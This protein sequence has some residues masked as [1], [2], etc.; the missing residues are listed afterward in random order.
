[1]FISFPVSG[2]S[3][4]TAYNHLPAKLRVL[5]LTSPPWGV[6][7][8]TSDVAI[9]DEEISVITDLFE[10]DIV[11]YCVHEFVPVHMNLSN[12]VPVHVEPGSPDERI[13]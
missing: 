13:D 4:R 1:M 7:N 10:C 9:K 8:T 2:S 5:V 11:Y 3:L 6:F 12:T